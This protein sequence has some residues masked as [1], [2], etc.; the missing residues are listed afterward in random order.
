MMISVMVALT[1]ATVANG[2]L[3][4]LEGSHQLGR[5]E[6]GFSGEQVGASK[7]YVEEA[8]NRHPLVYV[9]LQP[10]DTLFFHSNLLH[11]SNANTSDYPRWSLICAY[12]LAANRPFIEK[13]TSSTTPITEVPNES[14]LQSANQNASSK[15]DFLK[16]EEDIALITK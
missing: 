3:Q 8:M 10:G 7:I 14:I 11:T 2:C 12:N 4:V 9:E 6:H 13:N 1:E 5:I 16:V 15:R